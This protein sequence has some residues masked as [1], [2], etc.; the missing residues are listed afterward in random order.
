MKIETHCPLFPGFY[1]TVFEPNEENEIY[2]H[3]QEYGTDLSYDDFEWHY[4]DYRERVASAFVESFERNFQS[5]MPAEIKYQSISSPA[6]YNFS[7]DSIN[8][9]V[10]LDFDRFME[11][12]NEKKEELSDYILEHYTSRDGFISF[13]SNNVDEWCN[14]EYVLE[15]K[16]HRVGALME[17]LS[18]LFIDIEDIFYWTDTEGY[19]NYTLK[20]NK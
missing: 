16:E 14:P 20:E 5:I 4:D 13:H 7:N 6:Y 17:A 15:Q 1:N 19:I 9:E 18:S 11:I 10:D 2:S 3:N 12:V 8:I